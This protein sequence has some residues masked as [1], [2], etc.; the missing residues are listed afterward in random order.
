M[1]K[2]ITLMILLVSLCFGGPGLADG[3]AK[4]VGNITTNG[5]VRSDFG[6]YW[7]QITAENE[8]KWQSIEGRARGQRDFSGCKRA[9]NWAKQNGAHFKFHALLWGSQYPTWL[10]SLNASETKA[11]ITDWFDAVQ[12]EFPDL[13]MIDVVNEAIR[14]GNNQYHSNYP[15]TKII[16]AMGGDNNGDYAFITNAFKMARE[17]WP[18][19]ILIYNDY[20]T[21]Q[22]NVDQGITLINTIRKNGAPID[23]Y[24]LQ[25]HDLM[26]TGG[27][28]N[29]TGGGGNCL[30]YSTFV[31]TMEKIHKQ[32]N[33]F[34]ILISEYDVPSTDDGIQKQCYQEQFKYWMEDPYV[35]GITIWGYVYGSTWLD[36]NGQ[37]SG[38]SGLIK[39]NQERPALTWMKSYLA[40]NKG[41]NL[42][43]LATGETAEPIPQE[44]FKELT[45][46]GK[47]QMEDFD[48][49]GIGKD[50][51]SY[52][53]ADS[54]NNGTS[55]YRKDT[56]VDLYDKATGVVLGY[57]EKDEWLEYTVNVAETGTYTMFAA[58]ASDAGG[59]FKLSIDGKDIT[60]SVIVPK[61][62]KADGD[63]AQNFDDFYKAEADV[64]LVQGKHILR[65][66]ALTSWFD[67]DY[68][69]FVPAGETDPEPIIKETPTDSI[70]DG[71]G[72][73]S[74]T[75]GRRSD[76]NGIFDLNGRYRFQMNGSSVRELFRK[77][78]YYYI[79]KD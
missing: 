37:A 31:S 76:V 61:A 19:A 73:R 68:I 7:N 21:I 27:G 50:N 25:A 58:V 44:P 10:E 72:Q 62:Q 22:W 1:K 79:F 30:N 69:T 5:Q 46:P 64:N 71:L 38:C 42:T 29:G 13:E 45:I 49:P 48:V 78:K 2:L 63:T 26:S 12:K 34:P 53:D 15:K 40:E 16:E 47:I 74:F 33:N 9:Y 28:Y 65:F 24:G 77:Q 32:T 8:C 20:N 41:V 70:T 23:A 17:R 11:A 54:K 14:T 56:G 66:T 3:A 67:I 75:S 18:K 55:S 35:A 39:N 51:D 52:Y 36:C 4:F 6:T 59:A 43:G 57:I 60:D